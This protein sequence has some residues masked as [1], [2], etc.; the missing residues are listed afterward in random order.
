MQGREV[1]KEKMR[2]R[3]EKEKVLGKLFIS[4]TL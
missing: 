4:Q 2:H 3:V 1:G